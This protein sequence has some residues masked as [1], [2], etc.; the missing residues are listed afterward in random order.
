MQ[1]N[2]LTQ[3]LRNISEI[4]RTDLAKAAL[5]YQ[6]L[7][8]S[9]EWNTL[10]ESLAKFFQ[11]VADAVYK[12]CLELYEILYPLIEEI[13]DKNKKKHINKQYSRL[14]AYKSMKVKHQ[15]KKSV[16]ICARSCLK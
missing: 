4:S 1:H 6:I 9:D 13:Y 14:D 11:E 10:L 15:W 12:M 16:R 3:K 7:K 8:E 2:V 5:E